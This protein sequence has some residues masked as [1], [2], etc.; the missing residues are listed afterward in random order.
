[1]SPALAARSPR[2]RVALLV[3]LAVTTGVLTAWQM[4]L[5][6]IAGGLLLL[7]FLGMPLRILL[8]R[9]VWLAYLA[10]GLLVTLPLVV[11]GEAAFQLQAGGLLLSGS[12]AGLALAGLVCLRMLG[13]FLAALALA[14]ST[15]APELL[16]ALGG[17][18]VPPFF[19][20]LAGMAIRYVAVLREEAH[21]L[22]VA[23]RSRGYR[24]AGL[25]WHRR[26][27][28]N[29]AQTVGMLLLRAYDRSERIYWAMM[30]RSYSLDSP[31]VSEGMTGS[32]RWALAAVV[33]LAAGLILADRQ[34]RGG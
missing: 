15:P 27:L 21:R 30:S 2:V 28:A 17:L 34:V 6:V 5:P 1:M 11:P 23:R 26:T 33:L 9:L 10:G 13:C 3:A 18:G 20:A 24:P 31:R 32:E 12:R 7:L 29:A 22:M 4:L 8:K 25:L 14:A 16:R 19:V